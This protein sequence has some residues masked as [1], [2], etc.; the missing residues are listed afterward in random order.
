MD[1]AARALRQ[2]LTRAGAG[3]GDGELVFMGRIGAPRTGAPGPRS[4]RQPLDRL[5]G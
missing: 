2:A 1:E 5:M 4:V 3:A